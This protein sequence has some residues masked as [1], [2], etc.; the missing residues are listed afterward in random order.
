ML[1]KNINKLGHN[2]INLNTSIEFVA[3]IWKKCTKCNICIYFNN[4]DDYY[5]YDLKL[6][7]HADEC[8]NL[9][10]DEIIIKKHNRMIKDFGHKLIANE[11]DYGKF[12]CAKCQ[13]YI[14]HITDYPNNYYCINNLTGHLMY[15]LILTCDEEIIKGIIE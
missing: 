2:F 15:K 6:F 7:N 10:C 5:F 13:K 3:Q 8:N 1:D 12:I 9:T 14:Y 11:H 4:V